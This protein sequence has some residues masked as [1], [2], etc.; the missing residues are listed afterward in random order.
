M[1]ASEVN[2]LLAAIRT[3][4]DDTLTG[5]VPLGAPVAMVGYPNHANVGDAAIWAGETVWLRRHGHAVRYACD[6]HGYSKSTLARGIGPNG[7]ILLHGGGNLGDVWPQHQELREQV[8]G[9]FPD[10]RIV[11]FPQTMQFSDEAALDRARRCFN[12]HPNITLLLRD[13]RSLERARD[14]FT[15]DSR[16][17]PDLAFELGPFARLGSPDVAR[18]WLARTDTERTADR[19]VPGEEQDDL[20]ADWL[21]D[22]HLA[23]R[24]RARALKRRAEAKA[25]HRIREPFAAFPLLQVRLCDAVAEAR[26]RYGRR[27]LSRGKV[28]ITDRL[29]AHIFCVLGDIPHVLVDT[30]YGKLATF[31][32]AWTSGLSFVRVANGSAAAVEAAGDLNGR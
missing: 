10:H 18:L 17:C 3:T 16:L 32:A 8:V 30:G 27:L 7:T 14:A 24:P 9:D 4:I 25:R 12:S 29:H 28:V 23:E 5:V 19:L 26:V 13:E 20:V 6:L 11:S 22:A 1:A 2:V 21:A 15:G 31:H